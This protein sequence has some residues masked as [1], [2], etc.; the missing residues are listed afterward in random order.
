MSKKK[1]RRKR[2]RSWKRQQ[3]QQR[4][5]RWKRKPIH[6]AIESYCAWHSRQVWWHYNTE[7]V[8]AYG[9]TAEFRRFYY[10]CS[11]IHS[12]TDIRS[13]ARTPATLAARIRVT[14]MCSFILSIDFVRCAI[15]IG[16]IGD[17]SGIRHCTQWMRAFCTQPE[18]N[19][20][21]NERVNRRRTLKLTI[22]LALYTTFI[23]Q[24]WVC[25]ATPK[26]WWPLTA[27][28]CHIHTNYTE[29][30]HTAHTLYYC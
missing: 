3:R 2:T 9:C 29:P 30:P 14:Q 27:S 8:R 18:A 24:C 5:H 13:H 21:T 11:C 23:L 6:F 1:R 15:H 7:C 28:K 12:H 17:D 16:S 10:G 4:R 20:R 22:V 26:T 19:E 25:G